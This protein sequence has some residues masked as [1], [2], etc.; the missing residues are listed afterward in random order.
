MNV[1]KA[2]RSVSF[3][4]WWKVLPYVAFLVGGRLIWGSMESNLPQQSSFS[5]TSI[6]FDLDS[7]HYFTVNG[8]ATLTVASD[9]DFTIIPLNG[10]EIE[11]SI[12]GDLA[13]PPLAWPSDDYYENSD[14]IG[15]GEWQLKD[16]A[17]VSIQIDANSPRQVLLLPDKD[18]LKSGRNH[19]IFTLVMYSLLGV[20]VSS[21]FVFWDTIKR[22]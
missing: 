22:W 13:S 16:G 3:A 9:E 2:Q 20:L 6:T 4:H 15:K 5:G 1:D 12:G 17:A 14:V 7:D 11:D 19:I 18:A 10:R 21:I 8:E